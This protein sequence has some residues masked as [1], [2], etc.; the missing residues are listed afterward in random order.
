[1]RWWD[2][3]LKGIDT[4]I[5]KE[6]MYR[7]WM[8]HEPAMRGM[9]NVPGRWV[10]E[11][12]WPSARIKP[13]AHYLTALGLG[14]APAGEAVR[15]LAS[16]QTVG[17]TA[18]LWWEVNITTDLPGDQ[19]MDDGRS[20]TFD[21]EP[22]IE[23]FEILGAPIVTLNV[24][25]DKP[26]A[27]LAVRLNE[28]EPDGVSKRITYNILNLTHRESHEFPQPL[29]PGQRYRI[30][31]QLQDC[32]HRFSVGSRIRLAMSTTYWPAFWPS[33]EAVILTIYTG[34]S[35]LELPVRP[36]R[37]QDEQLHPFGAAFVPKDSGST[38]IETERRWRDDTTQE[39]D[40]SK[41][42]LTVRASGAGAIKLNATGTELRS[43]VSDVSVI[44]DD[45]PQSAKLESKWSAGYR[46]P[47]WDVNLKSELRI[48]LTKD[49]FLLFGSIRAYE[50]EE[51]V[52]SRSW[53]R[54]IPRQLV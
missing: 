51:E 15:T 43:S 22:L 14:A 33:P 53:D 10:A 20:L 48:S 46:R 44:R 28:V 45:D 32:A 42:Q 18:P 41:Q 13:S 40:I 11:D 34:E 21:S 24:A 27:F 4:G 5:M 54:K 31:I 26:V 1:L 7:A 8:Q 38:P 12:I 9:K 17:V 37:P 19:R 29:E 16:P 25:V 50:G 52:F 47:D 35:T 36:P 3:W 2:Y 23:S 30:R 39:W 49:N 6:P